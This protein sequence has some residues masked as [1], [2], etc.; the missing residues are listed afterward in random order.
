MVRAIRHLSS[1]YSVL[2]IPQLLQGRESPRDSTSIPP[3]YHTENLREH[4]ALS[5]QSSL[6]RTAPTGSNHGN[7]V[8]VAAASCLAR[9]TRSIMA[10][11]R[12]YK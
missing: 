10:Y 2:S 7:A 12:Q 11:R 6:L 3:G 5:K 9:R 1:S 4:G 8:S